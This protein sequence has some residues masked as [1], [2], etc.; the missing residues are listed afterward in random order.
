MSRCEHCGEDDHATKDC[1]GAPPPLSMFRTGAVAIIRLTIARII[2]HA[3]T[4]G[5][6]AALDGPRPACDTDGAEA[7]SN[8]EPHPTDWQQ[9][10]DKL[11]ALQQ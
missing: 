1:P 3:F 4:A 11:S 6:K 10:D 8:Y 2:R 5:Y 9:I 7:F